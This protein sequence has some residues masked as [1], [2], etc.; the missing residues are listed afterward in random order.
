MSRY[1]SADPIADFNRY[2]R[3]QQERLDKLPR[4]YACGEPIQEGTCYGWHGHKYHLDC[5]DEAADDILPEFLEA[6][7]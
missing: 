7:I 2:D 6:T 3:E 4:C 1:Y 5:K